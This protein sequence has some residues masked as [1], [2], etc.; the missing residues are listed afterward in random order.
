MN[1]QDIPDTNDSDGA[2]E[3]TAVTQAVPAVDGPDGGGDATKVVM[4]RRGSR[5]RNILV[6]VLVLLSCLAVVVTGVAWWTHYSVLN[7]DGYMKIVG[8]V[9]KDPE[10]IKALSDYVAGQI[11]TATDLQQRTTDALP[12]KAQIFAGPITGALEDFIAK[13]TNKVLST[14]QAYDLWLKVNSFAHEKIVALLRGETTNAYIQGDDVKLDT[15]PLISQALVWLDGKLPGALGTK[16]S[17]PVIAPGTPPEEAIQQVSAW[18]GRPLPAD[19]GQVT[20]LQSDSLGSAQTA[21]RWF[22]ALV[23]VMLVGTIVLIAVT[24]WLSRRRRRTLIEL[25]IGAAFALILTY[26]IAKRASTALIDSIPDG[27]TVS[28]VR[29]VVSASLGPFTTLTIWIVVIGVIVAVAAWLSGRHDV[30][31]AVV[32]AG[33]RVVRAPE[34]AVVVESPITVWVERYAHWLRIAGAV[35]GVI[36]LLFATSSW[37]GIVLWVVVILLFEGVISFL[38]GEWP[39]ERGEKGDETQA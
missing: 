6:G 14:P 27:G 20:L 9:G 16:F 4:V 15:L 35:A 21:V 23:W 25:G 26:V 24:I 11:V 28:L 33:K 36:L 30:Q 12:P 18:T 5:L 10:A 39:F 8:P 1:E 34:D 29:D 13:G 3:Q 2:A 22:D 17:P 7:T 37:L 31:V 19:F 38:I 32:T